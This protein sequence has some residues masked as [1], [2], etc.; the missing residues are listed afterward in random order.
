MKHRNQV[1]NSVLLPQVVDTWMVSE[2]KW[3][4]WWML[5]HVMLTLLQAVRQLPVSEVKGDQQWARVLL[6]FTHCDLSFQLLP[7]RKEKGERKHQYQYTICF[8]LRTQWR[9][10]FTARCLLHVWRCD[11]HLLRI[12]ASTNEG[13]GITIEEEIMAKVDWSQATLIIQWP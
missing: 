12:V 6:V 13:S 9:N 7:W 5:Q 4:V 3:D 11:K 2:R 1:F 10:Y 8:T